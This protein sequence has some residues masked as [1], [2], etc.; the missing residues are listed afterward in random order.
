M[1]IKKILFT[2]ITMFMLVS[3]QAS[4]KGFSSYPGYT[5]G[6]LGHQVGCAILSFL[7]IAGCGHDVDPSRPK[8]DLSAPFTPVPHYNHTI[9]YWHG[10]FY[11]VVGW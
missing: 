10:G 1:K 5:S 7:N 4:A 9:G 3:G 2:A 8:P 11:H 6:E